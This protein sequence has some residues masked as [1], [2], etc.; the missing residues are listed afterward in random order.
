MK[1]LLQLHVTALSLLAI[2]L[3]SRP[4]AAKDF[5]FLKQWLADRHEV[6]LYGFIEVRGGVRTDR[7]LDER[8]T[9]L[10]ETRLQVD[11]S[12]YIGNG[13][14]K[15]KFDLYADG[16]EDELGAELRE[17]N[18]LFSPT[19]FLDLKVGRQVLTWGTG[20]L[21]FI[22]DLFPKD[23]ESFFIG[24]DDEYLKAPSDAVKASF[25][26]TTLNLDLVYHPLAAT[27]RYIDGERLSYWNGVH[28]RLAG[29]DLVFADHEPNRV[30]RDSEYSARLSW[31]SQGTEYALYGFS[32][33]WKTPEGLSP[34]GDRLVYPRLSVYGASLRTAI[35]GGIGNIEAGYYHSR[36]DEDGDD[37]RIRNSEVRLLVGFEKEIARELTC[38][39]QYYLEWKQDYDRYTA[40]LSPG[41]PRAD[42]YRH[43]LTLRL[44]KLLMNQNLKLSFFAYYSPSDRDAYLRPKVHYKLTDQWALE[45][46]ANIFAGSMDHTFWGQFADNTNVYG[47]LRYSY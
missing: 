43:L 47:S 46:G 36:E 31:T 4:A 17:A 6:D 45:T 38:G 33:F 35:G 16:V 32:G 41:V 25:F 30:F 18:Y 9:S 40:S 3:A 26:G 39:V 11:A 15:V 44:T 13:T 7:D 27:S 20:D 28:G 1:R 2:C 14:A 37:P 10:A 5:A 19:S 34:Q 42:E 24:R 22:N 21:L 29:R 12:R 8:S 23:W